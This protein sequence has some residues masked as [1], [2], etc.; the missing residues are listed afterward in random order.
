MNR[1]E[2]RSARYREFEMFTTT[3]GA[4]EFA[5]LPS[6]CAWRGCAHSVAS[7]AGAKEPMPAGW[8]VMLAYRGKAKLNFEEIRPSDMLR[9][10]V[11][12]PQH[13]AQLESMLEPLPGR[14][15]AAE[16]MGTA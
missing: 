9:D 6:K 7:N 12:C 10:T 15:F 13:T 5:A 2:R 4:D 3:M 11:L 1:H 8:T 14:L 16:P